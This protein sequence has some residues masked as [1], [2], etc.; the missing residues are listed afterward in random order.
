MKIIIYPLL[1]TVLCSQKALSSDYDSAFEDRLNMPSEIYELMLDKSSEEYILAEKYKS[2][3]DNSFNFNSYEINKESVDKLVI[4]LTIKK[5]INGT[6]LDRYIQNNKILNSNKVIYKD[7]YIMIKTS[8]MD[9]KEQTINIS[10][11]KSDK[12]CF[13][14]EKDKTEIKFCNFNTISEIKESSLDFISINGYT[15]K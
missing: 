12:N 1:L 5:K 2:F 7:K 8:T 3:V 10:K 4:N 14:F 6:I 15:I 9:I 13:G 11:L